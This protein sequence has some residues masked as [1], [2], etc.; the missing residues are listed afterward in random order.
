VT[1]RASRGYGARA[2]LE[3][4]EGTLPTELRR[5]DDL[6]F[7][8]RL[9][10]RLDRLLFDPLEIDASREARQVETQRR[11]VEESVIR[12]L[13]E[14]RRLEREIVLETEDPLADARRLTRI[15]EIETLVGT[16]AG[17][18]ERPVRP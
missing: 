3:V 1:L 7:E 16:L 9:Q 12:L 17:C 14:R 11:E 15:E 8:M 18:D 4:D 10:W 13:H 5:F 6:R 2:A